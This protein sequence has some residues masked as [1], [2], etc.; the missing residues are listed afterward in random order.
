MRAWA[1]PDVARRSV[2]QVGPEPKRLRDDVRSIA[3]LNM[4]HNLAACAQ[5]ARRRRGG[6]GGDHR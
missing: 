3:Q 4:L 1:V 6:R 2:A 5:H